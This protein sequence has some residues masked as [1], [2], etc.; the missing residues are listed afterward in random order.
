[1]N[2][3]PFS[4]G[5]SSTLMGGGL[6]SLLGVL[7]L[8]ELEWLAGRTGC[9]ICLTLKLPLCKQ[10]LWILPRVGLVSGIG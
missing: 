5:S 1:M 9:Q 8:L 6:N 7:W 10:L 4:L 2:I 3:R